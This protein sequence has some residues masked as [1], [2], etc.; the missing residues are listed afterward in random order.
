MSKINMMNINKNSSSSS[1]SSCGWTLVS[2]VLSKLPDVVNH[3]HDLGLSN[4]PS[5]ATI[6]SKDEKA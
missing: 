2:L 6:V 1:S 5:T 3:H 4:E